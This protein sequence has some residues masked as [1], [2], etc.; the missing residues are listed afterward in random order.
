MTKRNR[1]M[2]LLYLPALGL[3]LLFVLLPLVTSVKTS[4]Y[5]WNGYSPVKKFVGMKNYLDLFRDENFKMAFLNTI[6]Y[7]FGSTI[8][9]NVLGLALALFL[10][11]KFAGHKVVRTIVYLP[12]M[13]SGLIMGYI[14]YFVVQ[15]TGAINEILGWPGLQGRD[16]MAFRAVGRVT[17][18]IDQLLAV[19]WNL[20]LVIPHGRFCRIS[21]A[22]IGEAAATQTV[23][24]LSRSSAPLHRLS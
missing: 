3:V 7:G 15:N 2:N 14:M 13:I 21:P 17:Y 4:F 18:H 12:V 9:Q 24:E 11:T 19:L 20:W 10:N 16:W 23:R 8:L 5:N 6:P 1:R 22:C